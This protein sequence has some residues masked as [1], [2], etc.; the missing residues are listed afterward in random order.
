[1][2]VGVLVTVGV[3][4]FV[5]V[6]VGDNPVVGVFVGVADGITYTQCSIIH[7]S[8]STNL[9]IK[10]TSASGEGTV[11]EYGNVVTLATN[12]QLALMASQ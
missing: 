3:A 10:L 6:G 8:L 4:V 7:P 11:N 1:V 5:V 9:T 2:F 12:W